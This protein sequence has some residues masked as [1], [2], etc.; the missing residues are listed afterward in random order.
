[1]F[2]LLVLV[3]LV[4]AAA[5]AAAQSCPKD[6]PD[7]PRDSAPQMLEGRL[8]YHNGIRQWFEL[9]LDAPVCG[10]SSIQ[11]TS[12]QDKYVSLQILRGCRVRAF[13]PLG[14]PITGYYSRE[15]YQD[16]RTVNAVGHCD[17]QQRFPSSDQL[18]PADSVTRYTVQM[19][20]HY[21]EEDA[22][23]QFH[24]TSGN[25]ELTPWQAYAS[26]MLT[27][28]FVL[29]GQCAKGFAVSRVWGTPEASPSHLSEP[30]DPS[31]SATY[32]PETA[33]A[34]GKHDLLL[35]YSCERLPK[36]HQR[37]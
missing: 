24:I 22:P 8:L 23:V 20:V 26:Y 25:R 18:T 3:G 13:G 16:V 1:M 21:G 30:G 14:I 32:D 34:K 36:P 17:L 2:R 15:I 10:Q 35:Y 9:K 12:M 29:Y 27:G 31:D 11:L 37:K 7:G 4:F 28:G 5:T 6:D 19:H 33:A